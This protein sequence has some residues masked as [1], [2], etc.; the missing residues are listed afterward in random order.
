MST[1]FHLI[2]TAERIGHR[3]GSAGGDGP[4]RAGQV[5]LAALTGR[6]FRS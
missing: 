5:D 3:W 4:E 2:Y 1:T 6:H